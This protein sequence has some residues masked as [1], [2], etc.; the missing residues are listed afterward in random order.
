MV[1][2]LCK[3]LAFPKLKSNAM[4]LLIFGSE[5]NFVLDRKRPT[6]A[7]AIDSSALRLRRIADVPFGADS[8]VAEQPLGGPIH[9]AS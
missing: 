8:W 7:C 6:S 1:A 4:P 2:E 3:S 5:Q 9:V